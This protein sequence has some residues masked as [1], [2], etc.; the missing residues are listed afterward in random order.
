[1]H[2]KPS[3]QM[4][5]VAVVGCGG[6]GRNLVRVFHELGV[7]KAVCDVS[8]A[9][10][11]DLVSSYNGVEVVENVEDLFSC[12]AVDAVVIATPA[13]TH[14]ELAKKALLSGKDVFVEK[15]LALDPV[16]GEE[17]IRLARE[18]RRILM[19]GHILQYHP[20]IRAL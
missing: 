2:T 19:V 9:R 3:P 13:V 20:A 7:L 1:M 11:E 14:Y 17:L 4:K 8:R 5:G 16:H 18:R 6:W 10:A 15:P 12:P